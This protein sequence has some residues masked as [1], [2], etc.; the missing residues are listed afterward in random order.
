MIRSLVRSVIHDARLTH[1]GAVSLQV[2]AFVLREIRLDS[3]NRVLS[4]T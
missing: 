2:D 3:H 4:V 1:A